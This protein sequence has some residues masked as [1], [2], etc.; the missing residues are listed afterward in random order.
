MF[1]TA[2]TGLSIAPPT[3]APFRWGWDSNP[4]VPLM[5][6][7]LL[8]PHRQIIPMFS[9]RLTKPPDSLSRFN[10]S[11]NRS[12]RFCRK[13]MLSTSNAMINTGYRT[14]FRWETRSGYICRKNALQGP[15]RSYVHFTMGLTLSPRLWVTMILSSTLPPSLACTQCSMWT[16]SAIFSTIIGHLR[17]RRTVDTN[18]AQP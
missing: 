3:I 10:T 2:T 11:A 6:H 7:Y 14:S 12:M 17:D 1:N 4:W 5:L 9:L 13:P 16:S 15:I 8:Q 18:R